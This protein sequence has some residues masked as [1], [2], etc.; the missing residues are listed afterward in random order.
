[1]LPIHE[2]RTL[3]LSVALKTGMAMAV[4]AVVSLLAFS[5]RRGPKTTT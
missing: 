1:M 2:L 4:A 3:I 5:Y